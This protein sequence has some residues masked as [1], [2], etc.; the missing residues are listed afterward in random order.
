MHFHTYSIIIIYFLFLHQFLKMQYVLEFG[1]SRKISLKW[2]IKY[3]YLFQYIINYYPL[4]HTLWKCN[5]EISAPWMYLGNH[6]NTIY[7]KFQYQHNKKYPVFLQKVTGSLVSVIYGGNTGKGN[8][9][10]FFPMTFS[11]LWPHSHCSLNWLS[12][13]I[14]FHTI[15]YKYP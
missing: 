8:G 12:H 11:C 2:I 4:W 13:T 15:I 14:K 3:T 6:I 9:N 1:R 10:F 5:Y 7:L